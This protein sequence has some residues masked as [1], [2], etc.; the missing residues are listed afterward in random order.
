MSQMHLVLSPS[1]ENVLA[2][3]LAVYLFLRWHSRNLIFTIQQAAYAIEL[4]KPSLCWTMTSNAA[5]LCQSLGYH[6]YSTMKDDTEEQ[7]T[8][9]VHAFWFIYMLDKNLSLRLGRASSLQDWDMV[10]TPRIT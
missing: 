3:L 4:S 8:A 7:R 1:Y 5:S 9:K 10:Q 2:L 6:R